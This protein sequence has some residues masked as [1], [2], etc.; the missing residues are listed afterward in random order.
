[1]GGSLR[2]ERFLSISKTINSS[3]TISKSV[4]GTLNRKKERI[5]RSDKI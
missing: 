5:P 2:A 1:L 4:C 3:L